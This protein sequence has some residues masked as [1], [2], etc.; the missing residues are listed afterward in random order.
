MRGVRFRPAAFRPRCHTGRLHQRFASTHTNPAGPAA[1]WTTQKV[2]LLSTFTGALT[3]AYGTWDAT[4][5][6]K[7][8]ALESSPNPQ[9][10]SRAE[11]EKVL[12]G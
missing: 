11:M 3:Y 9:Y 10:A 1:F 5:S 7:E 2:L 8:N 6:L 12:I 4:S